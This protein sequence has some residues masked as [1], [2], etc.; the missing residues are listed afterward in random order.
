MRSAAIQNYFSERGH[1]RLTAVVWP[2]NPPIYRSFEKAG[3]TVVGRMGYL[4][5][6]RFRR[7]FLRYAGSE[8]PLQILAAPRA[9]S[10]G[11][12]ESYWDQ[13]SDSL[14]GHRHYLDPF[15]GELKRREYLRLVRNWGALRAD[16]RL[17]KT[18]T[19][20]E[21]MGPDAFLGELQ[22][23]TGEIIGMD[24][25]T[26]IVKR[27]AERF[28]GCGLHFLAADVRSLPFDDCCFSTV[29]SPSTLDH[30]PEP[31]D[32]GVSLRELFRVLKPGG[33][34]VITLDNRRNVF[35]P[36]L[37]LAHWLGMVPYFLGRSYT[38]DELRREL[39]AAGFQV[40]ETTAILHNP[41]LVAMG[42]MRLARWLRWRALI[43]AVQ[44]LM[45]AAQGLEKTR[46][47]HY[48]GSFVAA[49]AIRPQG[50]GQQRTRP[51]EQS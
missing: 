29:V 32:L 6:G 16:G 47:C 20:E 2:E 34:L 36:V 37:R 1:H 46:L 11:Y 13:V 40:Q 30:F 18:D 22:G 8:P 5:I 26:V 24:V 28:R 35:D 48:T 51:G 4:G 49:L 14:E 3:Y 45:L 50:E 10:P 38:V 31:A 9:R 12:G 23:E 33:R 41:R 15:L 43:E 44:R 39:G 21:A 25:S 7:C 42:T 19:F 27:A 17:L